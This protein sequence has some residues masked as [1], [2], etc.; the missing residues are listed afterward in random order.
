MTAQAISLQFTLKRD[1]AASALTA[2]IDLA[3]AGVAL[4]LREICQ[5][6]GALSCGFASICA[7]KSLR[8]LANSFAVDILRIS[9]IRSATAAVA[10]SFLLPREEAVAAHRIR[11]AN[12]T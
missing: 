7:N 11:P 8:R 9:L 12:A 1:L 3:R 6:E 4:R 2:G 5:T 10:P